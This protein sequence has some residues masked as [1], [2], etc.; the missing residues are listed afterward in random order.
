[1]KTFLDTEDTY[2]ADCQTLLPPP[3]LLLPPLPQLPFL[4]SVAEVQKTSGP[5]AL[6]ASG[7]RQKLTLMQRFALDA[8][9]ILLQRVDAFDA[10]TCELRKRLAIF[11]EAAVAT[12]SFV[13]PADVNRRVRTRFRRVKI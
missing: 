5:N 11:V 6:V 9:R 4:V 8:P 12:W 2:V 3:L 1:M 7:T 10:D 13:P